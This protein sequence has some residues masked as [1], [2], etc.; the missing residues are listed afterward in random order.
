ML[1][2]ILPGPTTLLDSV[3]VNLNKVQQTGDEAPTGKLDFSALVEAVN[4]KPVYNYNGSLTTP[5][6]T[7]GVSWF[8]LGSPQSLNATMYNDIKRVMK[9]NARYS[10][11]APG[12]INLLELA[13]EI[14]N[15]GTCVACLAPRL[16]LSLTEL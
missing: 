5:P 14:G 7:E 6:C 16:S 15:N 4:L 12:E 11:N 8:V 2:Q 1:F 10:Q 9:F 3:F 13:R